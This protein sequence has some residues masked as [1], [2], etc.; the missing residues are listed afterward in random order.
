MK[1]HGKPTLICGCALIAAAASA[2]ARNVPP[3]RLRSTI[4][5][6]CRCARAGPAIH[7]DTARRYRRADPDR[8][9]RGQDGAAPL[10]SDR[11][12]NQAR[13]RVTIHGL[14]AAAFPLVQAVS[15]AADATEPTVVDKARLALEAAPEAVRPRRSRG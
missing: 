1:S 15:I 9:H 8:R 14:H 4:R 6:S 2:P 11:L 13:G 10:H 3:R 5:S 12:H 7:A